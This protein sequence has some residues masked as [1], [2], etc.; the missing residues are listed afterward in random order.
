MLP[1]LIEPAAGCPSAEAAAVCR[2]R[3]RFRQALLDYLH[4]STARDW[5]RIRRVRAHLLDEYLELGFLLHGGARCALC[6]VTVRH[7][8][9][10]TAFRRDG[11]CADYPCLC[12]RCLVGEAAVSR[13][14]LERVGPTLY[15]YYPPA[16]CQMSWRSDLRA[17]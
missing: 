10:V 12:V 8:K 11:T 5:D 2:Q 17:A 16:P 4:A 6:S 15:E 1:P 7:P 9:A 14:T 3:E 13:H